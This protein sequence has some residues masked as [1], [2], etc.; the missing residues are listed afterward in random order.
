MFALCVLAYIRSSEDTWVV[1]LTA[2][3][4]WGSHSGYQACLCLLSLSLALAHLWSV[5]GSRFDCLENILVRASALRLWILL[6]HRECQI[7][8]W[9]NN[10]LLVVCLFT[11]LECVCYYV[12][13][14]VPAETRQASALSPSHSPCPTVQIFVLILMWPSWTSGCFK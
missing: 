9:P 6:I 14:F 5:F 12:F 13:C 8:A 1:F 11:Y 3:W 7:I 2:S 4:F 10:T